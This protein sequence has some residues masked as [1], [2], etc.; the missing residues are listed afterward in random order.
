M[1]PETAIS[2]ATIILLVANATTL[3]HRLWGLLRRIPNS[4]DSVDRFLDFVAVLAGVYLLVWIADATVSGVM[5]H[6]ELGDYVF[7]ALVALNTALVVSCAVI[8]E[9]RSDGG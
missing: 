1:S 9:R 5:S 6:W 7:V 2:V 4:H 3:A 8:S